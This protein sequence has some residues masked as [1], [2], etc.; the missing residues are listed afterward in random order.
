MKTSTF[1]TNDI[2]KIVAD[3]TKGASAEVLTGG[4]QVTRQQ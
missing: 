2:Q 4:V 3:K 1:N